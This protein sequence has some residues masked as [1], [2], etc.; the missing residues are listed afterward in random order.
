MMAACSDMAGLLRSIHIAATVLAVLFGGRIIFFTA[1][2][3]ERLKTI[4]QAGRP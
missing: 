4:N 1:A 2:E 3:K